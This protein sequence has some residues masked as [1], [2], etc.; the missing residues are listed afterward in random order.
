MQGLGA[1]AVDG[2]TN[3]KLGVAEQ[4]VVLFGGEEFCQGVEVLVGSLAEGLVDTFGFDALLG[5]QVHDSSH[6]R[7]H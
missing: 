7:V 3:L 4:F 2:V 5:G 6:T 1:D